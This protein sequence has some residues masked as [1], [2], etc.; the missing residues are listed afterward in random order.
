[1]LLSCGTI[2]SVST[3]RYQRRAIALC[4][5]FY[6]ARCHEWPHASLRQILSVGANFSPTEG[7][8]HALIEINAQSISRTKY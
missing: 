7:P 8:F 1:M 6:I 5:G 2:A 4:S 3:L